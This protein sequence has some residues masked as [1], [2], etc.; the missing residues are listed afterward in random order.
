M[1]G[2]WTCSEDGD[3]GSLGD[4]KVI[5]TGGTSGTPATFA[6][7]VTADRAGEATLLAA[8]SCAKDMTLTYQIRPC[9]LRAL[10]ISFVIA[11]KTAETDYLWITGTDAWG[12]ALSEAIDI[13]AGN[14]T[15]TSTQ[16]FATITDIDVEDAGDGTGTA[17]ADGTL[18]VTQA[19]WGL[20]WDYGGGQYKVVAEFSIGNGSTSTYFTSNEE[21]INQVDHSSYPTANA[22]LEMGQATNT[23]ATGVCY[24]RMKPPSASPRWV[25]TI[26]MYGTILHL[27]TD[28]WQLGSGATFNSYNS[29]VMGDTLFKTWLIKSGVTMNVESLFLTSYGGMLSDSNPT[30]F[31]SNWA[32]NDRYGFGVNDNGNITLINPR[33]TN[34][35]LY[36]YYTWRGELT[37]QDPVD[38]ISGTLYI[39]NAAGTIIENYTCNIQILDG[40]GTAIQSATVLCEDKDDTQIFSVSTDA[41]GDITEQIITYRDWA[42]TSE[43]ET[44]HSPHKFTISKA[45]YKTLVMEAVTVDAPIVWHLELQSQL[46]PVAAERYG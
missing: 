6:D 44:A 37:V 32:H 31:I 46:M 3:F 27:N 40:D 14:G 25:G 23:Y 29:I 26:N 42:T 11:S 36:D 24:W 19:Q 38:P 16:Y 43:T 9:E 35:T 34:T 45:G 2:T 22:T 28:H 7:F 41:S 8:T 33:H 1:A 5:V 21:M 39:G 4:N 10:Q 30:T 20:V 17:A 18:A 15:Y 13:S 12:T